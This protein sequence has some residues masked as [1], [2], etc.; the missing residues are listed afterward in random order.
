MKETYIS[1]GMR[2]AL[3]VTTVSRG[4]KKCYF[5]HDREGCPRR[6]DESL[7]CAT[8]IQDEPRTDNVYILKEV[9]Q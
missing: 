7:I 1:D 3:V 5:E 6:K 8:R 9:R 4:C 2:F